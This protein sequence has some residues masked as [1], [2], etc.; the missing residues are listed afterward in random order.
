MTSLTFASY[1]TFA[2]IVMPVNNQLFP[3]VAVI[4]NADL[5]T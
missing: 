1:L 5:V 2:N 3:S 4:I